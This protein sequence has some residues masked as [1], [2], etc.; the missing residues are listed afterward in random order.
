[1]AVMES[2]AGVGARDQRARLALEVA[3]AH[4][5]GAELV[6]SADPT[7]GVR[8]PVSGL[9]ITPAGTLHAAALAAVVELA[10]YLAVLPTLESTEH[11]V[12]HAISTQYLRAARAGDWVYVVGTLTKRTR[13]LAFVSV[14]AVLEGAGQER[15]VAHSQLT[16]S[17]VAA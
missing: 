15:L 14:A 11:A 6:D 4:A 17:I 5:L 12:T 7:A 16:K 1:M 13:T 8:F 10:G 3:L 9:A 2:H